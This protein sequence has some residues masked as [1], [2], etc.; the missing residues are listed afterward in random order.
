M[1]KK[2]AHLGTVTLDTKLATSKQ[3]NVDEILANGEDVAEMFS[4]EHTY[5]ELETRVKLQPEDNYILYTDDGTVVTANLSGVTNGSRLF[6]NQ[7]K[8]TEIPLSWKLDSITDGTS[9]C[10]SC[11]NLTT[12]S[13]PLNNLSNG[14]EMFSGCNLNEKSVENILKTI[15]VYSSGTHALT[16]KM[17]SNAFEKFNEI[18]ENYL[19]A[20]GTIVY[21]GW[22]ITSNAVITIPVEELTA[23]IEEIVGEGK[24]IIEAVPTENKVVVHTDRV[25]DTQLEAVTALLEQLLPKKV[26]AARYNHTM[27]VDWRDYPLPRNYTAIE[28]IEGQD[29]DAIHTDF[30]PSSNTEV[31]FDFVHLSEIYWHTYGVI[32]GNGIMGQADAFILAMYNGGHMSFDF[33]GQRYDGATSPTSNER[34]YLKINRHEILVDDVL[35][36]VPHEVAE[37]KSTKRMGIFTANTLELKGG[38]FQIYEGKFLDEGVLHCHFLPALDETGAP[39]LFDIVGRVA[40]YNE[41]EGDFKYPGSDAQSATYSLRR[42]LPDWGKLT[43]HGLRRLYHVPEGYAGELIDYALANGFKPIVEC[44]APEEGYWSPRWTETEKEIILEWDI[45]SNVIVEEEEMTNV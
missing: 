36:G 9:M 35:V 33:G 10:A 30:C 38:H 23:A 12:F 27:D 41:G 28:W 15:P 19:M 1:S 21:K 42:V 45:A 32:F 20:P 3:L 8:L 37:F 26:E 34:H 2:I 7:A 17:S 4:R 43:E 11:S 25:D 22:E 40:Y 29:N 39:C 16:L 5:R 44:D 18:T 13:L 31:H 14:S 24:V 6:Y